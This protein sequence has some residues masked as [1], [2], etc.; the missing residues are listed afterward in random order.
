MQTTNLF[1]LAEK[2]KPKKFIK[3]ADLKPI[4]N[5]KLI[6]R[7]IRD[8][9]A[10]NVTGITRDEKIA[11]N[12]MRLLF[13]KIY[14]EKNSVDITEFSNR[15][16]ED[17][18]IFQERIKKLFEKVKTNYSDI[19][20]KNE[21][22]EIQA[23]QLSF[24]VSKLEDYSILNADRDVIGDAFEE[25]IGTSFRGGEGQFFTPRNVVQMMIDVLQPNEN[26]SIIDPAC[27][28]GGFLAYALRYLI[29][30][31]KN[32][33]YIAGIDKDS[34][35]SKIAKIYLSL[36]G[37]ENYYIHCENSLELPSKWSKDT[38]KDINLGKFDVVL[39]NPPFGSKIPVV[40]HELLEQYKLGH[41]WEKGDNWLITN[42]LHEKQPPQILFIERCLQLLKDGGRMGIV[43]P[44][45]IFGNPSDKYIWEYINS[46]ASI[47][48]VVSLSQETFQPST[49]TKTSVLFLKK[50]TQRPKSIFM[51][52][53]HSIGH[54]KNGKPIYKI[55]SSGK[56]ILDDDLPNISRSFIAHNTGTKKNED[57]L[58]FSMSY[59]NLNDH[60]FI[61][62]YY[63]PE[64]L[65]EL[66]TL[67]ESGKYSLASIGDLLNKGVL[68]IKRGNEIGSQNYGTGEIPF[69]RTSDIVNWEIKFDPIK[70][71]SEDVYNQYKIQQDVRE[72]D[73]LFVNDGTFLIGRTAMIT[74]LD[75]KIIIQSHVRK[76][77]VIDDTVI[78]PYYL[79]YLLNSK[80][81]RKQ[82]DS[83]TFVQATISTIGN[84]LSEIILP[85]SSD[86]AE[87]KKIT[88]E[89]KTIIDEK[90]ELRKKTVQIMDE[91][92]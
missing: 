52:I 78:D 40:G 51:A 13:C 59:K 60:I 30:N 77:R 47:I 58:G 81:V 7:E 38:Q 49:H 26:E 29:A 76:I 69:V 82:I 80:I 55:D 48:G 6:F 16:N 31:K 71:V 17:Y 87:I 1:E 66:K 63:N 89:I 24:I 43:L 68:Q 86:K 9:F 11:Q 45:G 2:N 79:F 85:I 65:Q 84:R 56:Q 36:I 23:E 4:N 90:A 32:K 5:L 33:Y 28:S 3:I 54:N 44:E 21:K 57:H 14:D 10:G 27:G 12:I 25:L 73:I 72:K 92:I 88:K 37:N 18:K 75:L 67:K 34:F 50:T 35:L 62:E 8:Y 83:R 20:D 15:P 19:F 42:K 39:T 46:V 53:A 61:P 70:A 74:N 64:I 91:S 22:I 41:Q